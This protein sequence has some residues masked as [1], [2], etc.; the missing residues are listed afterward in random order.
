SSR[1]SGALSGAGA[2]PPRQGGRLAAPL[3]PPLVSPVRRLC[4]LEHDPAP[5]AC[6]ALGRRPDLPRAV[7]CL[8]DAA[9]A[10]RHAALLPPERLRAKPL[11][12]GGPAC[13]RGHGRL[14]GAPT[15]VVNG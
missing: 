13:R 4:R 3:P 6:R 12:G 14:V 1:P 2:R 7:P 15:Q 10:A 8:A 5:R 11:R 9:P